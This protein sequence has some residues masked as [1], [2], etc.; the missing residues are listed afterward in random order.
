MHL[1][2]TEE[3]RLSES[4]GNA[5]NIIRQGA[6]CVHSNSKQYG[7]LAEQSGGGLERVNRTNGPAGICAGTH[8]EKEKEPRC[9][10]KK[11]KQNKIPEL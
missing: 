8:R 9:Q 5:I 6:I 1:D 10:D 7:V 2:S 3:T 4:S 11:E